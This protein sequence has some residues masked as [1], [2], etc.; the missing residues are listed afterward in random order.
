MVS[1]PVVSAPVVSAPVVSEPVVSAPVVSE[2]VV[3]TTDYS[4]ASSTSYAQVFTDYSKIDP[5]IMTYLSEQNLMTDDSSL[6]N[7][8]PPLVDSGT[9]YST[10]VPLSNTSDYIGGSLNNAEVV[11]SY[12]PSP[13]QQSYDISLSVPS[14]AAPAQG[15]PAQGAPAQGA[16]AQG[17]PAQ[18]TNDSYTYNA[19]SPQ[20]DGDTNYSTTPDANTSTLFSE[21]QLSS[22]AA[23]V[24]S[25]GS[26]SV[27]SGTG[28]VSSGTGTASSGTGTASSGTG[29][30]S[31]GTGTVSSGTGTVSSG[32]GTGTVSNGTGTGTGTGTG[33]KTLRPNNLIIKKFD[34]KPPPIPDADPAP[35][36]IIKPFKPNKS[37]KL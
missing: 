3:S 33:S 2:P 15:A 21:S 32:T 4:P 9:N 24:Y 18:L 14:Q 36:P 17:A 7:T 25:D 30:V 19:N 23:E 35:A 26:G 10:N 12:I 16:P 31:S 34:F 13:P 5:S 37:F 8:V 1:A 29:T 6:S 28:S 22:G 27:S 11:S 20:V